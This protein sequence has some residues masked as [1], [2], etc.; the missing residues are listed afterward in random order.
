MFFRKAKRIEALEREVE[1][2]NQTMEAVIKSVSENRAEIW[3]LKEVEQGYNQRL[4]MLEDEL[5]EVRGWKAA[6]VESYSAHLKEHKTLKEDFASLK[7]EY[8]ALKQEQT[9]KAKKDADLP[10]SQALF[11][12]YFLYEEERKK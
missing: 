7:Q 8:E 1:A 3:G 6:L 12:E 9:A 11:N 5:R 2:L 10:T 4:V